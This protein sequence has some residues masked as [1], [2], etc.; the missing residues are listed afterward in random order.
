MAQAEHHP[1]CW[2]RNLWRS[3]KKDPNAAEFQ[4]FQPSSAHRKTRAKIYAPVRLANRRQSMLV[5]SVWC[6]LWRL[7]SKIKYVS[8]KPDRKNQIYHG[9]SSRFSKGWLWVFP[10]LQTK[11]RD[12]W[13]FPA[14]YYSMPWSL[15]HRRI[16]EVK[17]GLKSWGS[18]H[19][20]RFTIGCFTELES[21]HSPTLRQK[22]QWCNGV[23]WRSILEGCP[24]YGERLW[25]WG[26]KTIETE[27]QVQQLWNRSCNRSSRAATF[28]GWRPGPWW[29]PAFGS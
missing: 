7:G 29:P 8:R 23:S 15:W 10:H 24:L 28:W 14:S 4:Q 25:K 22:A 12:F 2:V 11:Q 1:T 5:C 26:R 13:H 27:S 16:V 19:C 3:E 9:L 18:R 6:Q 17:T 20:C 21:S